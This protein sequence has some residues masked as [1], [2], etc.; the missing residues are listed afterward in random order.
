MITAGA[1]VTALVQKLTILYQCYECANTTN[2]PVGGVALCNNHAT[3]P[4]LFCQEV[5]S[6]FRTT[7]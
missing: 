7:R 6:E 1:A 5:H 4:L 3:V 2:P